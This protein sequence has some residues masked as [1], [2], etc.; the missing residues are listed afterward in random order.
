ML[1]LIQRDN[2]LLFQAACDG[3]RR[4]WVTP[5]QSSLISRLRFVVWQ[6]DHF[7]ERTE[8]FEKRVF[9]DHRL[10]SNGGP[11]EIAAADASEEV[12]SG[13]AVSFGTLELAPNPRM[14]R[15]D[16]HYL[17]PVGTPRAVLVMCP[18]VNGNG[19]NMIKRGE[20]LDFALEH[21][22]GL[23]GLSFA[24][25]REAI[26]DGTG[27]YYAS[28]GSG[29]IFMEGIREIYGFE[30]PLIF[31]GFSGG[32]HFTSRFV[33]WK[34]E[35]VLTWA[36]Y[37]AGWWDEPEPAEVTPPG[38]VACGDQDHRRYGPSLFYFKQGRAAG[39]PWLWVSLPGI[40]HRTTPELNEFIRA[41]FAA[42]LAEGER[43]PQ[44]VD[45]YLQE[46]IS[47]AEAGRRPALSGWLPC[48]QLLGPWMEVHEP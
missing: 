47:E 1:S 42:V 20:W 24:S 9:L 34:P 12:S 48:E 25:P 38:L 45:V 44:W 32:A 27:Y 3:F 26:H 13:G 19:R 22:L 21:D 30:P 7:P 17:K 2:E 6:R 5:D 14:T 10:A 37:S 39:K 35:A 18:G 40:G 29:K 46:K 28:Q 11:G 15:A 36:A 4:Y 33:E 8:T 23:V 41:Y 31:C 16:L 43:M